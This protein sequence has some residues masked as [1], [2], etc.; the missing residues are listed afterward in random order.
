MSPNLRL[1][2]IL[3]GVALGMLGLSYAFVP[4]YKLFCQTFGIPVPSVMVGEGPDETASIELSD[5]VVTVRFMANQAQ[6]VPVR[7]APV[8]RSAKIRVGEPFLTAYTAKNLSAD[9][10]KGTAVHTI[11]SMGG[12]DGADVT[13]H[14]ALQQCFCFE[15][16][17]Y[18]EKTVNDGK[19]NLPLSFTLTGDLP[20]EVHTITFAYTLFETVE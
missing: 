3:F 20:P 4:L 16:Q 18:P 8:L 6:G 11:F 17:V 12:T 9:E 5:R 15:E 10:F 13:S 14:V 1:L 2:V 7:L 19:V